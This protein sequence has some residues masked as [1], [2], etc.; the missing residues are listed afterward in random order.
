MNTQFLEKLN[1]AYSAVQEKFADRFSSFFVIDTGKEA[2]STPE[3]TAAEVV[4]KIMGVLVEPV[5][6]E[7]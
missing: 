2:D 7:Q 3:S 6:T 5:E 1:Q 4:D